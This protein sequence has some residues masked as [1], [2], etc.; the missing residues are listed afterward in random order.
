MLNRKTIVAIALC[1]FS[2]S[3]QNKTP[4]FGTWKGTIGKYKIIACFQGRDGEY[5]TSGSYYY[6]KYRQP[7]PLEVIGGGKWSE[8]D[9]CDWVIETVTKSSATGKWFNRKKNVSLPI[10]LRFMGSCGSNE[11]YLG[12]PC[13][14]DLYNDPIEKL[15]PISIDT[16]RDLKGRYYRWLRME[17][18]G[19]SMKWFELAGGGEPEQKIN[20]MLNADY[21]GGKGRA[22]DFY[23][24]RRGTLSSLGSGE[25]EENRT[26]EPH[27]WTD[28][29][30]VTVESNNGFCGGAHPF[31]GVSYRVFDLSSGEEVNI[32]DWEDWIDTKYLSERGVGEEVN[33]LIL[34]K[35]EILDECSSIVYDNRSYSIRP[36]ST[37]LV[38]YT[39]FGHCCKACED[40]YPVTVEELMPFLS[41]KGKKYVDLLF[42]DDGE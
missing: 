32:G 7:I 30:L 34:S 5:Y 13:G 3:A 20:Q 41:Q 1:I 26:S 14:C 40:E 42:E 15:P 28:R 24:C 23:S 31:T 37:G 11:E 29:I 2:S 35:S 36:D 16:L 8:P 12:S 17:D 10:T 18:G 19:I 27:L 6:L 22:K 38:F 4:L 9:S 25:C 39:T 21:P 33:K